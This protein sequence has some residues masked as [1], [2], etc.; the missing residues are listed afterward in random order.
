MKKIETRSTYAFISWLLFGAG[1]FI[2]TAFKPNAAFA[3]YLPWLTFGCLGYC[4][5]RHMDKRVNSVN[6]DGYKVIGKIEPGK[7]TTPEEK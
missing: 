7:I 4:F 2:F 1:A 6:S 3:I 5:K